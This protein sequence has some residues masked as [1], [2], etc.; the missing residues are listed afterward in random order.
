MILSLF[1]SS[2]LSVLSVMT[3]GILL[4][5]PFQIFIAWLLM[6][7]WILVRL[8]INGSNSDEQKSCLAIIDHQNRGWLF[9]SAFVLWRSC[10]RR[11]PSSAGP[12]RRRAFQYQLSNSMMNRCWEFVW[13][14]LYSFFFSLTYINVFAWG[15][16]I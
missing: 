4:W 15:G 13:T 9:W 3:V 6:Q 1:A 7:L 14:K 16:A 5:K 11:T 8:I 12:P 10:P 2:W